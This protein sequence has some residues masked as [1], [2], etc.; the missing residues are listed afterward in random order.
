MANILAAVM[1]SATEVRAE[2]ILAGE[3]AARERGD[4][5]GRAIRG[6]RTTVTMEQIAGIRRL[7]SVGEEIAAIVR[8]NG[9]SRPT[10][11]LIGGEGRMEH[12]KSESEEC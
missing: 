8:T 2:R 4:H 5:R 11:H 6:R 10:I 12:R 7:R 9:H 1:A 3:A